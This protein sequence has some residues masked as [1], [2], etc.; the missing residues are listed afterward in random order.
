MRF[1]IRKLFLLVFSV[2]QYNK[3]ITSLTSL[4]N[5]PMFRKILFPSQNILVA[6]LN[7]LVHDVVNLLYYEHVLYIIMCIIYIYVFKI[8]QSIYNNS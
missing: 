4:L 3:F 5:E 2:S 7:I 8:I 1:D 6:P